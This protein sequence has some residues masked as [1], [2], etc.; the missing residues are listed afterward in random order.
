MGFASCH[1]LQSIYKCSMGAQ[2]RGQR[3]ECEKQ[4]REGPDS[5]PVAATQQLALTLDPPL[6]SAA[7]RLVPGV[8]AALQDSFSSSGM[9]SNSCLY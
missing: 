9:V 3:T 5:A 4:C 1:G 2:L 8:S 6:D 7:Q